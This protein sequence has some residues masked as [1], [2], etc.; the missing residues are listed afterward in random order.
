VSSGEWI[1]VF[2]Y[3]QEASKP[4]GKM[5]VDIFE[6]RSGNQFTTTELPFTGSADDLFNAAIWVEGGYLIVPL[7]TSMDSFVLWSVPAGVA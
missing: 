1:A 7:N 6:R 5:F 3:T 4:A 2:S